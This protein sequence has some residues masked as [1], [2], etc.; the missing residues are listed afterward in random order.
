MAAPNDGGISD[1]GNFKLRIRRFSSDSQD[2]GYEVGMCIIR[3]QLSFIRLFIWLQIKIQIV[4]ANPL[5]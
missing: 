3:F 5:L 2:A 4:I 1:T